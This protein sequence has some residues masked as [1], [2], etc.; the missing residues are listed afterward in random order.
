MTANVQP[1][2]P[3]EPL[4][5]M[6]EVTSEVTSEESSEAGGVSRRMVLR[7]GAVGGAGVALVTAQGWGGR[8][9]L[10]RACCRP[11]ARSPPPRQRSVISC[12]TLRSSRRAR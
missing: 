11:M 7:L 3:E 12:S 10:R 4:G 5:E 2:Q 9:L 8:F 1:G 6:S